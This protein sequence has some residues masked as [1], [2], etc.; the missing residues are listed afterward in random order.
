MWVTGIKKRVWDEERAE[1]LE[2]YWS[3][4]PGKL[5]AESV[6]PT[7]VMG[8]SVL[9]AACGTGRLIPR[10][11]DRHIRYVGVDLSKVMLSRAKKQ[12]DS[13]SLG[14]VTCL[15]FRD[16]SFDTVVASDVLL[17]LTDEET[18][19]AL[20]E[21]CRVAELRLVATF[22]E[23]SAYQGWS[24]QKF[25]SRQ[26]TIT[27]LTQWLPSRYEPY[28]IR[29]YGRTHMMVADRKDSSFVRMMNR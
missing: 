10:I 9:D 4:S 11:L 6:L 28:F 16:S 22:Q 1:E 21:F 23:G 15:P 5:W 12:T 13:L 18:H 2:R 27:D 17:H 19:W 24:S 7:F 3:R 25:F 29:L 8:N 14:D 26:H 20:R